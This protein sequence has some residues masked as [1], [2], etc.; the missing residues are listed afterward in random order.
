MQLRLDKIQEGKLNKTTD[1]LLTTA[2]LT[3]TI[4]VTDEEIKKFKIKSDSACCTYAGQMFLTSHQYLLTN[5]AIARLSSLQIPLCCGIPIAVY[6]DGEEIY[7]AMLWNIFSSFGNESI[8]ATLIGD[9]LTFVNQ[10]PSV[11]DFR[12]SFLANK[13]YLINCLLKR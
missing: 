10:L 2:K 7:R 12:N 8:T 3:D 11:P 13:K 5:K 1:S 4:L 6:V 9:T